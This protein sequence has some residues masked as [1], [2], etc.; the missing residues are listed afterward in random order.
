MT[1]PAKP[2]RDPHPVPRRAFLGAVPAALAA[3]AAAPALASQAAQREAPRVA[4]E[5]LDCAARLI[6]LDFTEDEEEMARRGASRNLDS[7]ERLRELEIPLDT[8]PAVTF[9]PY[10]PGG[11]P[12]AA[13]PRAQI[14]AVD[15]PV[16]RLG[17][18]I[19]DLAFQPVAAIARLVRAREV[20]ALDLTRMYL[21]RLKAHGETLKCVV[22]LTE[23]LAL[24]QA[25]AADRDLKDGRY[26]GQLHGIPWGAKDL[27]AT[28]GIRTT[29]GAKPY[30]NQVIDLDATVVERLRD[31][32][33][34]LVA[35]LSMGALAQ[36]GVWFGGSTRNPWNLEQSS[37]GSSA[38]PAAATAAGLVGFSVGTETLGS[39]IS[40][41]RACGAVG[42]RP[43]YGRISRYGAMALSWTMDKV[44]PICRSVEDCA[45]VFNALYGPD[46]RDQTV[47]DAPFRWDPGLPL[48][49]LAVGYLPGDF[50]MPPEDAETE[51]ARA[52]RETRSAIM[53]EALAAFRRAGARL[54][55]VTLPDFPAG[56][57]RFILSAE[58]AAAFDDLTRS[59]G[60]DQLTSQEPNDWPNTFRT[61]RFIPA[62]EYI[63]AQ[64]ART[65]LMREY[66]RLME[67]CDV[68][69]SAPGGSSLIATNLTGHP[70][71]CL[72]AGFYE[73]M[74]AAIM[75]TGR[76]Y[77][78]ATL[79]R[80]ALAFERATPW[81]GMHPKV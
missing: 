57:I 68:F 40:P 20:S 38:G 54:V 77:D 80:V 24:A 7:Y 50:E 30:E 4:A 56:A 78:E 23:D 42:L 5:A 11:R 17:S 32:G 49:R 76:L 36:G 67:A 3:G 51:E 70:A 25:A 21:A 26:R 37:S 8:E 44:G 75:I 13:G 61:S 31:A 66:A 1:L 52:R 55:P 59:R 35:K 29:W 16:V 34:V 60:I 45:L 9:R 22:T 69:L 46:G 33:A 15:P 27:F 2:A 73:K 6:G 12:P 10:L 71:L 65:L 18:S 63:R 79:L 39:I 74:P 14:L 72:K 62:V 19:D 64:R 53:R 43:T 81:A 28:R 48:G 41:A 58:A 47:V